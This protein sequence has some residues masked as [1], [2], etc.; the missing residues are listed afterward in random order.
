MRIKTDNKRNI[1]VDFDMPRKFRLLNNGIETPYLQTS[2]RSFRVLG[3]IPEYLDIEEII[4]TPKPKK[5]VKP[6]A[7]KSQPMA[8]INTND[9]LIL[10]QVAQDLELEQNI[11]NE[12]Q[13]DLENKQLY[14]DIQNQ[15][16][17]QN[18]ENVKQL[19][20]DNLQKIEENKNSLVNLAYEIGK[21]N[22]L[23]NSDF[24]ASVKLIEEHKQA[25]NPHNITKS[26]IGLDKVDNTSDIDKPISKAVKI[27]LEDKADKQDVEDI[28]TEIEVYKKKADR[29]D[30]GLANFTGGIGGNELPVGGLEGQV[31]AK[32]TDKTG[33]Y[34]WIDVS[35]GGTGGTTDHNKLKNRDLENQHP[36]NAITGLQ[37]NLT[38]LANEDISIKAQIDANADAIL[39][40][41]N[42]LQAEIDDNAGDI[43][44]LQADTTTI[45]SD[46][47]DLGD[48]VAGIE[49][50]IP[51]NASS[52][53]QLATKE[54]VD[55]TEQEI[56]ENYM[57]ADSDLQTQINGLASAISENKNDI[58]SIESKIPT[59][60]SSENLL[61]TNIDLTNATQDVRSDFAEADSELQIQINAQAT[62]I[63]QNTSDIVDIKNRLDNETGGGS[64]H[65]VGD[66]FY[67]TRLDTELNGAVEC[68]G[69]TY[70][71]GD[72]TGAESIGECLATG[73]INYI[74]FALYEIQITE[75][76]YC[77]FFA[78]ERGETFKV[79]TLPTVIL[80]GNQAPVVGNGM[81][82]GLTDGSMLGGFATGT[83]V[84][85]ATGNQTVYGSPVGTKPSST[86]AANKFAYNKSIGVTTDPTRSGIVANLDTI[87]VEYRA[88]VQLANSTTD[89]AVITVTATLQQL[90]DIN[91]QIDTK[92]DTKIAG[93]QDILVS[94]TNIKTINGESV[95]GSGN[96]IID[97]IQNKITNCIT[98]IP[99]DIELELNDGVLTLKA[100]SKVYIPNGVGV[101]DE[102]TIT[103][104]KILTSAWGN[105]G[106][107]VVYLESNSKDLYMAEKGRDSSGT[108]SPTQTDT[109]IWYDTTN[110]EIKRYS[111]AVDSGVRL[112]LPLVICTK[113]TAGDAEI[114]SLDQVFNG[115]GYIGSTV[116]SLPGIKGLVPNGRNA[117]G[118]LNNIE[119]HTESVLTYTNTSRDGGERWYSFKT[120][121]N[122][123]WE[124]IDYMSS[125]DLNN[126]NW[127]Y[128]EID[129]TW[130]Y[131]GNIQ[132]WVP[133]SLSKN[134]TTNPYAIT[135]SRPKNTFRAVDANEAIYIVATYRNGYSWSRVYSDYWC[136][137]GG[138][139]SNN[140]T[141]AR[142]QALLIPFK[143][144]NYVVQVTYNSS[145]D[146]ISN[147]AITVYNKATN[148]F[149]MKSWSS[150]S[151][152]W[153][154]KG[155]IA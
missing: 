105:A 39:K 14:L 74:N 82:L 144:T 10:N 22:E 152:C 55:A 123:V 146:G 23:V 5:I 150:D 135:Y 62:D 50:K 106:T 8:V 98:E 124:A 111:G 136:E 141:S 133:F 6:M 151:L 44:S 28:K 95:V 94:G 73:K 122:G 57:S 107:M 129:N 52:T 87:G 120:P 36:I 145:D 47:D 34:E 96:I 119:A 101:F 53:N 128:N 51:E 127:K 26:T 25:V 68:N 100:G 43:S 102:V 86:T 27:A 20:T 103:E 140:S 64:G 148:Q 149:I 92:I 63:T 137:Q 91:E 66:I 33:D 75:T 71:I 126:G 1:S 32:K 90:Q 72:F 93:K 84:T 58:V 7:I 59:I 48:Q 97:G 110:N 116:F 132:P 134:N 139:N 138:I 9:V 29:I 56:I 114:S 65:N 38:L 41:R 153:E 115:F 89:E 61:V 78:Y 112:S 18:V 130:T 121:Q 31:L 79:P 80:K 15:N 154:A 143:D 99:Q 16:L 46:L 76:G 2:K 35:G 125:A 40:T 118:S 21:T 17:L 11:L 85:G 70:N 45:K 109:R 104:D 142:T 19:E 81:T 3:D 108:T 24:T 54:Y 131:K 67:T 117:D 12:K 49:G 147:G 60:A 42:D 13:K 30:R 4:E 69:A 37:E 77:E 83:A 113:T 88:M 155:Y